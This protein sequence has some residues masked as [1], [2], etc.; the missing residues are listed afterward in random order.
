[1]VDVQFTLTRQISFESVFV[2]PSKDKTRN[3][4]Q[5]L[6]FGGTLLWRNPAPVTWREKVRAL[7]N[8]IDLKRDTA[9]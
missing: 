7:K 8:R 3:F 5:M 4:R 6:A 2:S 9:E 1:M